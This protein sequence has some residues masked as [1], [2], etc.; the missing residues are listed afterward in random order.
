MKRV[1]SSRVPDN[2]IYTPGKASLDAFGVAESLDFNASVGTDLDDGVAVVL[3]VRSFDHASER[4][5]LNSL[6]PAVMA[7]MVMTLKYGEDIGL[8]FQKGH[9][10]LR[11][12]YAQF[13]R[14]IRETIQHLVDEDD[15][16]EVA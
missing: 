12:G 1:S 3:R 8:A 13:G 9:D 15:F 7:G 10:L 11:I 5:I 2:C 6:T 4:V 14:N 16:R